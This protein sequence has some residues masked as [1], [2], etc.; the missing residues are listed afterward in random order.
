MII[1]YT[2]Y[3]AV[4][5]VLATYARQLNSELGA[6]VSKLLAPPDT[7][8][9]GHV[10]AE[11]AINPAPLFFFGHGTRTGLLSQDAEKIDFNGPTHLLSR[12][13]VCATCCHAITALADA[14]AEHEATVFG[15]DG[16]LAVFLNPPYSR[17]MEDCLLAGPRALAAGESAAE[18]SRRTS[19]KLEMLA[20]QL[21]A[22]PIE[23][24]VYATFL[25][26][27]ATLV[28]VI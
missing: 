20:Q 1:L 19:R 2:E 25:Q 12:R 3:D 13:V 14:S 10:R 17:L 15:Y 23:D 16:Y 9:V 8:D 22:G 26:M 18:A 28:R 11:L 24:Q 5:R 21:I 6:K 27:N 4:T 7:A